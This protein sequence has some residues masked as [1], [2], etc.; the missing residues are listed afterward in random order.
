[1]NRKALPVREGLCRAVQSLEKETSREMAVTSRET[2]KIIRDISLKLNVNS[3]F[4][5]RMKVP[6]CRIRAENTGSI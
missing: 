5:L 4:V 2:L 6:F 1:M 3:E